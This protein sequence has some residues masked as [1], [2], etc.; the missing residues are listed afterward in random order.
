MT[1]V[2]EPT[3]STWSLTPSA[4]ET[5]AIAAELLRM[6]HA[7]E[8]VC[9]QTKR[10]VNSPRGRKPRKWSQAQAAGRTTVQR[11]KLCSDP[12]RFEVSNATTGFHDPSWRRGNAAR[13]R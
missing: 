13:G 11:D 10:L 6:P 8:F 3:S 7:A 5:F 9:V 1:G 12:A 2:P 4:A